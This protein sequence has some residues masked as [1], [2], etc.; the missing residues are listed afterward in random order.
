MGVLEASRRLAVA[1]GTIQARLDRLQARGA[2]SGYGPD[3]EPAAI[4]YAVTA[5]M[6]LEISQGSGHGRIED[7]LAAIPELLELHTIT[8]PA[9]C[10]AGWWPAPTPTSSAWWMPCW[11]SPA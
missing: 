2:I 5:F 8:G 7:R 3:I 6:T 1:R 4:G 10:C 11:P 9:T